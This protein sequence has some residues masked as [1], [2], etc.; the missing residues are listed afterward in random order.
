MWTRGVKIVVLYRICDIPHHPCRSL[1]FLEFPQTRDGRLAECVS[2]DSLVAEVTDRAGR[3]IAV[4]KLQL[5]RVSVRQRENIG[6]ASRKNDG[7]ATEWPAGLRRFA[8]LDVEPEEGFVGEN[9]VSPENSDQRTSLKSRLLLESPVVHQDEFNGRGTKTGIDKPD[10]PN[11]DE[12]T[13]GKCA[14]TAVQE[15]GE[16]YERQNAQCELESTT[17]AHPNLP[18]GRRPRIHDKR[19]AERF[20]G[21]FCVHLTNIR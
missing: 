5:Q 15:P 16:G 3:G 7:C 1:W 17:T 4:D 10:P 21:Y 19:V 9:A 20:K 11:T 2:D 13:R 6:L 18:G 12:L 8:P 14:A